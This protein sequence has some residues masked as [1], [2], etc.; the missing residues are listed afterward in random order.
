MA[1]DFET[2]RQKSHLV[3]ELV[4][5]SGDGNGRLAV[6][7]ADRARCER[8]AGGGARIPLTGGRRHG[9]GLRRPRLTAAVRR[10]R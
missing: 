1:I 7:F 8:E 3:L 5:L 10:C 2:H 6:P 4:R 9:P